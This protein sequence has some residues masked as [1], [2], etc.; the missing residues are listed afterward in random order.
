MDPSKFDNSYNKDIYTLSNSAVYTCSE[1]YGEQVYDQ[2]YKQIAE[3]TELKLLSEN[4]LMER[5]RELPFYPL[6][7]S[8]TSLWRLFV[9]SYHDWNPLCDQVRNVTASQVVQV[10]EEIKGIFEVGLQPVSCAV[11]TL[12]AGLT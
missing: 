2:R 11:L 6:R 8:E 12:V 1:I 3:I 4:G 9:S 7:Q 5:L 10:L